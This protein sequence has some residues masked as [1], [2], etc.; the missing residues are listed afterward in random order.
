[1]TFDEYKEIIKND[2][3]IDWYG[4]MVP[5]KLV[6]GRVRQMANMIVDSISKTEMEIDELRKGTKERIKK[7]EYIDKVWENVRNLP[8]TQNGLIN[9][10][11]MVKYKKI[12]EELEKENKGKT[13]PKTTKPRTKKVTQKT[14]TPK[15]VE[16]TEVTSEEPKVV[17]KRR[18]KN[19]KLIF[20]K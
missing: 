4:K 6:N 7:Q 14:E 19:S 13:K 1:M 18:G 17:S 11:Y 10:V 20:G 5:E 9:D 2:E 15:K 8:F 3:R 16:K 12:L